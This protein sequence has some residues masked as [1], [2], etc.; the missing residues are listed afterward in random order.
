[1]QVQGRGSF[2]FNSF[3]LFITGRPSGLGSRGGGVERERRDVARRKR[4][5]KKNLTGRN[6]WGKEKGKNGEGGKGKSLAN[7]LVGASFR[8]TSTRRAGDPLLSG[9]GRTAGTE[10]CLSVSCHC[11]LSLSL[12]FASSIGA[13]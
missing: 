9:C 1:M 8:R 13:R 12:S 11:V 10:R 7:L 6:G 3:H 2:R 5:E 4:E